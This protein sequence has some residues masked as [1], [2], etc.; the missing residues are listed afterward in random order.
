[1]TTVARAR[2]RPIFLQ[3]DQAAQ[4]RANGVYGVK[5]LGVASDVNARLRDVSQCAVRKITRLANR[6]D[7]AIVVGRL[8]G[9]KTDDLVDD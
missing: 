2:E 4:M 7:L 5:A 1:M 6:H 3:L 9:K 8:K